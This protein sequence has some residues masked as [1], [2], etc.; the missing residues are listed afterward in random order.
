MYLPV[1]VDDD[2]QLI[3]AG[4]QAGISA[5]IQTPG[6]IIFRVAK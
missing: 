4:G 3:R 1:I 5:R 6:S 2:E